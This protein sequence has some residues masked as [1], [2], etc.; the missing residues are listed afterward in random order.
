[1]LNNFESSLKAIIYF[2]KLRKVNVNYSTIDE[3]LQNHP[4]WPNVLYISN[5]LNK[6]E[7]SKA[8]GKIEPY[9]DN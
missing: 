6:W 7:I 1:M 8:V 4:D 3:K 2:K 9:D 5:S